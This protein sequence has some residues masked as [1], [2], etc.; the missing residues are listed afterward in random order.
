MT[1]VMVGP[2][3][4]VLHALSSCPFCRLDRRGE[5]SLHPFSQ[6][7]VQ[8]GAHATPSVDSAEVGSVSGIFSD[9]QNT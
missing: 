2:Q 4:L 1:S 7:G 9:N 6:C 8:H 5:N 3:T